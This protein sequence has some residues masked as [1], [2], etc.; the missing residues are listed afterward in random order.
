MAIPHTAEYLHHQ[1]PGLGATI[2]EAVF[3]LEDG[4]VSTL[5]AVTG[6]AA[7]TLEPSTV[8]LSGFVLIAVEAVSMA[9]GSYVSNKSARAV[10]ERKLAEERVELTNYPEEE[11]QELIGMYV[12]D[13]WPHDLAQTM[14]VCAAKNHELMLTEMAYR[15]L[16]VFPEMYGQPLSNAAIMGVAYIAGGA[17]PLLPYLFLPVGLALRIS[18]PVTLIG[19]F[20]VG[21]ATTKFSHRNWWKAGLEMLVLA[22][23]AALVGYGVGQLVQMSLPTR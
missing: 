19:L 3:G 22:G 2:R 23:V 5:G 12:A 7:A 11:K 9:V 18:I 8:L 14:A 10:D 20:L 6:I 17:V 16:K 21:V 13:G 1:N 4:M 15:E